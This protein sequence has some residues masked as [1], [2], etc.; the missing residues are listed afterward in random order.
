MSLFPPPIYLRHCSTVFLYFLCFY[1]FLFFSQ[2]SFMAGMGLSELTKASSFKLKEVSCLHGPFNECGVSSAQSLIH[3]KFKSCIQCTG[4]TWQ[5]ILPASY[6]SK[7]LWEASIEQTISALCHG[8]HFS[9]RLGMCM[10][11][12]HTCMSPGLLLALVCPLRFCWKL[13]WANETVYFF[14][15][16]LFLLHLSKYVRRTLVMLCPVG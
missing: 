1:L 12:F 13:Y 7:I 9:S 15:F 2:M 5:S 3:V 14:S 6:S 11:V 4:K 8:V 10:R 16:S